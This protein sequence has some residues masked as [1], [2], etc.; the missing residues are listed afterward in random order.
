MCNTDEQLDRLS[1]WPAKDPM[2]QTYAEW[3][4]YAVELWDMD[5]GT[6]KRDGDVWTFVTG[7]WSENEYV[8]AAMRRHWGLW[9]CTWLASYRGGKFT[10]DIRN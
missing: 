9:H 3:L 10:F 5:Y 8:I 7:G 2:K 1:N 6:A 4:D